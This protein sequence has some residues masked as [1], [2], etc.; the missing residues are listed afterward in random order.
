M[1]NQDIDFAARA[2]RVRARSD[3]VGPAPR[4]ARTAPGTRD[5]AAE[6]PVMAAVVRVQIA[7]LL[8][9]VAMIAGRA[10]AMNTLMIEPSTEVLALSEG[11]CVLVLLAAFGLVLGRS[12]FVAHGAMVVGASLAFLGEGF[13]VPLVPGLMEAVYS[14][15]YVARVLVY[16][17]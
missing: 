11:L 14:P 2:R 17:G 9:I 10:V 1:S 6:P 15:E 7:F 4:Q 5:T 13:Y 8:G 3:P 12:Q 16:S